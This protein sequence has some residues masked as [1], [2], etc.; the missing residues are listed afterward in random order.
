MPIEIAYYWYAQGEARFVDARSKSEFDVSHIFGAVLSQAASDQ[1]KNDPVTQWPKTD[2]IITYCGC[3]HTLSSIRAAELTQQGYQVV[4]AIDEGY[5]AWRDRTYPMAGSDTTRTISV[6]TIEGKTDPSYAGETAW[7]YH[8][9]SDQQEATQIRTDG[10]Y[11]LELRFID[12]TDVSRIT[13]KTPAYTLQDS[14][15]N[16]TNGSI[17]TKGAV[18]QEKT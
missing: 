17:S 18:V 14:L 16:L 2:R 7:A 3:P 4:Y 1:K 15:S 5:Q 8:N 6:Q 11:T 9:R 13:V 12:M 10:S